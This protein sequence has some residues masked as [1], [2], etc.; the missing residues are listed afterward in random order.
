MLKLALE[1]T[2][3]YEVREENR[4]T[5]ALATAEDFQPDMMLLDICMPDLDGG[6]VAFQFKGHRQ[7][8]RLPIIFFTSIVSER[9]AANGKP[10][11]SGGFRVLPK[12]V[13]IPTLIQCIEEEIDPGSLQ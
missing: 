3:D 12:T 6:E 13:A 1:R 2:G 4:A 11:V 10:F 9:D 7:L 8:K 5:H